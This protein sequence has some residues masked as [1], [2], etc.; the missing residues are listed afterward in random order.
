MVLPMPELSVTNTWIHHS[1]QYI[2][3]QVERNDKDSSN[4][5]DGQQYR[6]VA[7]GQRVEKQQSHTR[8]GKNTLSD[9]RAT[10][11]LTKVDSDN[12]DQRNNCIPQCMPQQQWYR[13]NTF[14]SGRTHIILF[15]HLDHT[16]PHIATPTSDKTDSKNEH[17]QE[18]VL[19]M[20]KKGIE[21]VK[22]IT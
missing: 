3:Y 2:R 9:G 22:S 17:G 11:H 12:S 8:P 21:R 5:H 15:R 18:Q 6:K 19:K 7:I 16:G 13:S 14:C 1:V 4:H 10:C 20:I